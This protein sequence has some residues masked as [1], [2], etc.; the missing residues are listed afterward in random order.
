MIRQTES[1]ST[2][3]LTYL[4]LKHA[5]HPHCRRDYRDRVHDYELWQCALCKVVC[6]DLDNC[7]STLISRQSLWLKSWN[8]LSVTWT[9]RSPLAQGAGITS[10]RDPVLCRCPTAMCQPNRMS[11]AS[12]VSVGGFS[13]VTTPWSIFLKLPH[14]LPLYKSFFPCESSS[15][16]RWWMFIPRNSSSRPSYDLTDVNITNTT[17][18]LEQHNTVLFAKL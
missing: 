13:P 7:V 4:L 12:V 2:A 11:Q 5:T 10:W 1:E 15:Q 8:L 17:L 18:A 14:T 6:H 9:L 3:E 16:F